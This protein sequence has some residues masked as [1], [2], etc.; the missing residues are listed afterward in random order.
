MHR[1]T[2]QRQA[3][4]LG[5]AEALHEQ[6]DPL[7]VDLLATTA[8]HMSIN[9]DF[10][11]T[12]RLSRTLTA[13]GADGFSGDSAGGSSLCSETVDSVGTT[14][15]SGELLPSILDGGRGSGFPE[16]GRDAVPR[17]TLANPNY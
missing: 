12:L 5:G 14:G 15:A 10:A 11:K 7:T 3:A 17:G 8:V 9:R 1:K 6:A 2:L 13:A 16:L 4:C